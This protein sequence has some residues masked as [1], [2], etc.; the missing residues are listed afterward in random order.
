VMV[1]AVA[2]FAVT[3]FWAVGLIEAR[4]RAGVPMPANANGAAVVPAAGE[5]SQP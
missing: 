3:S 5:R 2:L 1:L 4:V